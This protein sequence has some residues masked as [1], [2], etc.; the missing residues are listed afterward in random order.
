MA[1]LVIFDGSAAFAPFINDKEKPEVD[2]APIF[3]YFKAEAISVPLGS[4]PFYQE[5]KRGK[6]AYQRERKTPR[7]RE[8]IEN[9]FRKFWIHC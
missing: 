8:K 7:E 4:V 5:K 3:T 6:T 2:A 1:V 9:E